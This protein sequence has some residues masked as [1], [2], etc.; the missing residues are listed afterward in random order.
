MLYEGVELTEI[1]CKMSS[2]AEPITVWK[3]QETQ[4]VLPNTNDFVFLKNT[5]S[6]SIDYVCNEGDLIIVYIA[7]NAFFYGQTPTFTAGFTKLVSSET[8]IANSSAGIFY[9]TA[10]QT[11]GTF[12]IN[13]PTNQYA[14]SAVAF[15]VTIRG[16]SIVGYGLNT[17]GTAT[18]TSL[19]LSLSTLD[20]KE[21]IVFNQSRANTYAPITVTGFNPN[22]PAGSVRANSDEVSW[23]QSM[24]AICQVY[25][26][27]GVTAN[28]TAVPPKNEQYP[29]YSAGTLGA[30]AINY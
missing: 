22:T 11:N 6:I 3:V 9:A 16:G 17:P 13:C 12:T 26:G 27:T 14:E 2:T 5:K 8:T 4:T 25:R 7:G 15:L 1:Q 19:S 21:L 10:V 18:V 20:A 30:V 29:T 23:T 28:V 24:S